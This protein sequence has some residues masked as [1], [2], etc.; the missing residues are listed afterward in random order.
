MIENKRHEFDVILLDLKQTNLNETLGIDKDAFLTHK[1]M[2]DL[3]SVDSYRAES[4]DQNK[5]EIDGSATVVFTKSNNLFLI[6]YPYEKFKQL[7]G[8]SNIKSV[9]KSV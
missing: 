2:I 6:D 9:T 4:N 1:V 3:N 7:M 5:N 8:D